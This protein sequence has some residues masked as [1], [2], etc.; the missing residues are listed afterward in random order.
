[1]RSFVLTT[2]EVVAEDTNLAPFSCEVRFFWY[3]KKCSIF[4][5][6]YNLEVTLLTRQRSMQ[7]NIDL[8]KTCALFT[9]IN[10]K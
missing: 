5:S 1:M 3:S 8:E 9:F 4:S 7:L 10:R 2:T 6:L